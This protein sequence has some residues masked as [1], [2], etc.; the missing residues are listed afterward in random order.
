MLSCVHGDVL[1]VNFSSFEGV[2]GLAAELATGR[3]SRWV[4]G[5]L[6]AMPYPAFNS[7]SSHL[8]RLQHWQQGSRHQSSDYW[9]NAWAAD[10]G[11]FLL[12]LPEKRFRERALDLVNIDEVQRAASSGSGAIVAGQHIGPNAAIPLILAQLGI[13]VSVMGSKAVI[14]FGRPLVD[15]CLPEASARIRW[16]S[17]ADAHVLFEARTALRQGRVLVGFYDD[18]SSGA[19]RHADVEMLGRRVQLPLTLPHL[20][21]AARCSIVPASIVRDGGTHYTMTLDAA[22]TP[23]ARDAEAIAATARELARV[24]ERH[25][26]EHPEQWLGWPQLPP[27]PE[28]S[29]SVPARQPAET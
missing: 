2:L 18:L 22:L 28:T 27:K 11:T 20:A 6:R 1:G 25:I 9:E 29:V 24:A 17:T 3:A 4:V 14:D 21:A 5:G 10:M 19:A 26:R 15:A 12:H 13:E 8:A 23:P 16:L 7:A